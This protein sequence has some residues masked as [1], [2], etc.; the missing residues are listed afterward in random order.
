VADYG[1]GAPAEPAVQKKTSSSEVVELDLALEKSRRI[2]GFRALLALVWGLI[3]AKC[4]LAQWAFARYHLP[5]NT[6]FYVWTLSL[7]GSG[8]ITLVYAYSLFRELPTMPLS[9]RLAS[10]TWIA[11]ATGFAILAA[12]SLLKEAFDPYLLPALAAVLL[13][14]GCSIQSVID[15]HNLFKIL[16]AGWWISAIGMFAQA[17]VNALAWMALS[18]VLFVAAP[19]GWLFCHRP[20][21][22]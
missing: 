1:P 4:L 13:G 18:L 16:A 17:N 8:A 19:A 15:R 22:A 10:A 3:L 2:P 7:G 14:V 20:R 11:C 12:M 5:I 21:Q 6:G 9:G